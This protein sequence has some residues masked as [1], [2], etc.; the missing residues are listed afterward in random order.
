M[1]RR[2]SDLPTVAR[3]RDQGAAPGGSARLRLRTRQT[4]ASSTSCT[5]I[6]EPCNSSPRMSRTPEPR[7][8]IPLG[9]YLLP[10]TSERVETLRKG[11]SFWRM[12]W[13]HYFPVTI[14]HNAHQLP[15][16]GGGRG[17]R[18]HGRARL[19]RNRGDLSI[20]TRWMKP[21]WTCR[22]GGS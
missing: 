22:A 7:F 5:A 13:D 9:P 11:E 17:Y 15:A 21:R 3:L 18:G 20:P 1:E 19:A 4:T 2:W 14:M 10:L 8:K 16:G 12:L 6:R